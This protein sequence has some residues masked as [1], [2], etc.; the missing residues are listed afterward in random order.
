MIKLLELLKEM[1]ANATN[2]APQ[3]VIFLQPNTKVLVGDN[4]HDPVELSEDLFD[5]ILKIGR[6]YGYYGEGIG[7]EHNPGVISSKIYNALVDTK[8][9]Y[10]GSWDKRIEI[11]EEEKYVYI[12][13]LFSNP[14]E[15]KRIPTLMGKVEKGDT[16][17]DLLSRTFD[18]YTEPGLG[19]GAN[20]LKKFL[21]EMSEQGIDF[22][23]L[24]K[25]PATKEN[26]QSFV[27]KGEKLMWPKVGWEKYPNK[28]GKLVRRET[29]IRDKWIIKDS[30]PGVYFIGSGHLIDISK[31]TGKKIIGG[32][33]IGDGSSATKK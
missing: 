7:I 10:K 26:L 27:D 3:G 15:N 32:E 25:Q 8:S 22:I 5:A 30:P 2:I 16:I 28:A 21:E 24:S 13:T 14:T 1:S 18:D 12:A 29:E 31:M 17:F 6:S 19:L 20:D 4:H 11:P 33:K 23:K 9:T